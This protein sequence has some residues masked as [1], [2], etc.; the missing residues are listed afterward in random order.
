MKTKEQLELQIH[1]LEL[2][3]KK[4]SE[5]LQTE[6]KTLEDFNKPV[7][8]SKVYDII[9]D[10]IK[11]SIYD[12]S[13]SEHDFDYELSMEYDNRVELSHITFN[14]KDSLADD[15]IRHI[16]KQFK[17]EEE[18]ELVESKLDYES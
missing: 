12:V 16:N 13:F 1:K 17:V 10:T 5:E 4:L 18:V 7:L 15:I 3:I 9:V 2:Q 14:E 6:Q 8:T 11:E